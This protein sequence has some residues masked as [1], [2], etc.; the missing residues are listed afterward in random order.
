MASYLS[1]LGI[2]LFDFPRWAERLRDALRKNAEG[3]AAEAG[4]PIEFIRKSKAFR[5]EDRIQ[6]ILE[7]PD[8]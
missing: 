4:Q 8:G 2:R 6:A 1:K 7:E 5:K 3:I